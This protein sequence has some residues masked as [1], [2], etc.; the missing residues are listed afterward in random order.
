MEMGRYADIILNLILAIVI[1]FFPGGFT[2]TLFFG[3]A[4]S[5]IYIYMFDQYRVLRSVPACTFA[6]M[7]VDWWSQVMLIPCCGMIL[8][9]CI[10]KA[11]RQGY[12]Y[13]MEG[14]KIVL[15]CVAGFVAHFVVHF[16]MLKYVVPLFGRQPQEHPELDN[17]TY[18]ECN[19]TA[20]ASWFSTNPIH[21]LRSQK[22]FN[23]APAC[24]YLFMGKEHLLQVNESI[25]C[26]FCD[27][28]G[29]TPRDDE[30][31][32]WREVTE[33]AKQVA[34]RLSAKLSMRWS[35]EPPSQADAPR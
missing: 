13:Y 7:E 11:N 32:D 10:F 15:Y 26:Y 14:N 24:T 2:H 34:T 27:D 19:Q 22:I 4:F 21:C 23:H 33:A 1:L 6:N 8:M 3:M 31:M 20:A 30:D 29:Q 18:R 28:A 16:L 9:C 35:S 17:K 12:G 25:G 5:H